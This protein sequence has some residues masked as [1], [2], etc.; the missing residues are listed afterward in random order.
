MSARTVPR[1]RGIPKLR[2]GIA[3]LLGFGVLINYFDRVNLSVASRALDRQFGIDLSI[4]RS[5]PRP[6]SIVF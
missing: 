1:S 3:L 5:A 4:L 2:Y 6:R